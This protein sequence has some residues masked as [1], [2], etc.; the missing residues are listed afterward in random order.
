M[1]IYRHSHASPLNGIEF[2]VSDNYCNSQLPARWWD[3]EEAW[4]GVE[5]YES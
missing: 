4:R 5:K 3:I 2:A 1:Q